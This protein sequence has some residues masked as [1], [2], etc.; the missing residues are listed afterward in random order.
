MATLRSPHTHLD[1]LMTRDKTL[2]TDFGVSEQFPVTVRSL[3]TRTIKA[4]PKLAAIDASAFS[5]GILASSLYSNPSGAS[6]SQLSHS[7]L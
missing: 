5:V 2:M 1:L 6:Y 4:Y 3:A 7:V